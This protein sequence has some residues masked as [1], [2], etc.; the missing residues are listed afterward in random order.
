M[1]LIAATTILALAGVEQDA[2]AFHRLAGTSWA[3][4]SDKDAMTDRRSAEA[5][6]WSRDKAVQLSFRCDNAGE[7]PRLVIAFLVPFDVGTSLSRV[8]LRF[9]NGKPDSSL[10][11][12]YESNVIG[13][14][15]TDLAKRFLAAR[16]VTV[17][18]DDRQFLHHD[19]T[20]DP[21]GGSRAVEDVIAACKAR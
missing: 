12:A 8:T 4:W 3:L 15:P 2:M 17:R 18:I 1:F 5:R 20:F 10:W 9:D 19:A 7:R 14:Y 21:A 16:T 11:K 6:L 13:F